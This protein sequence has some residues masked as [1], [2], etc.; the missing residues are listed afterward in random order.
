VACH[1]GLLGPPLFVLYN[2]DDVLNTAASY[3]V[4]IH[5]RLYADVMQK[6]GSVMLA[7]WSLAA[8]QFRSDDS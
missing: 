7:L 3:E 6:V 4:F 8:A 1:R 2:S 5:S